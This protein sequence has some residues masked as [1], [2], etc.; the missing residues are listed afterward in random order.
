VKVVVERVQVTR[1]GQSEIEVLAIG[2][3]EPLL[4]DEQDAGVER[5]LNHLNDQILVQTA[6]AA[7]QFRFKPLP[8]VVQILNPA[9]RHYRVGAT[10]AACHARNSIDH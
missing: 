5:A 3:G 8:V 9:R 4:F 6:A 2:K 10:A 1:D 7:A